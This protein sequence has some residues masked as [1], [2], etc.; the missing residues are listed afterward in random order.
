[1]SFIKN[2]FK[3]NEPAQ[4]TNGFLSN[5]TPDA[6]LTEYKVSLNKTVV[7]LTKVT[8]VSFD[9]LKSR[10]NLVLDYSGSMYDLYKNGTVQRVITK[11]LPLALK[12]DDNRELDCYLFSDS[13]RKVRGCTESNYANYVKDIIKPK[14]E[15]MRGTYYAPVL[16][17]IHKNDSSKIP[18]FTIF[19]TDG[20]NSDPAMTDDII[21]QSC[22]DNGF[23]MFVGIGNAEFRY[24]RRLDTLDGRPVDNTGFVRFDDISKV[25]ETTLYERFLYEYAS[26]L[27][28]TK[29]N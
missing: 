21:R 6:K 2:L 16:N 12:F 19:I 18:T 13:F 24:L 10:V 9:K 8:G 25:D 7:N 4:P 23:I 28:L 3:K 22:T 17:K 1:M 29:N 20:D 15:A 5:D 14:D 26:W 27:T 11:I